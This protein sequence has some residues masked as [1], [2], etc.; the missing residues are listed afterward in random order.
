MGKVD[1]ITKENRKGFQLAAAIIVVQNG[2]VKRD[3]NIIS[4]LFFLIRNHGCV[5]VGK[6]AFLR[7]D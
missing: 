5:A 3:I 2:V 7:I 1:K 4:F 6:R